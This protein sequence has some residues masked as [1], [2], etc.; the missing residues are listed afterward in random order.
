MVD[1]Q[2]TRLSSSSI[3][4]E[5]DKDQR[6]GRYLPEVTQQI[7]RDFSLTDSMLTIF[8]SWPGSHLWLQLWTEVISDIV[9]NDFLT[10]SIPSVFWDHHAGFLWGIT[11]PPQAGPCG[12]DSII[13]ARLGQSEHVSLAPRIS[14]G[15]GI[16]PRQANETQFQDFYLNFKKTEFP[17]LEV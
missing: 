7:I 10:Q 14:L 13:W 16:N 17:F 12:E 15:M 8:W 2:W 5:K 1:N 3:M 11:P 6:R 9:D 4:D